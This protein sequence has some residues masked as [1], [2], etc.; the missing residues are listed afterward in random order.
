MTAGGGGGSSAP[1]V[2]PGAG[3]REDGLLGRLAESDLVEEIGLGEA[4]E[5]R[6]EVARVDAPPRVPQ[7]RRERR[8]V[9]RQWSRPRPV[10][11]CSSSIR[12][13]ASAFVSVSST[14]SPASWAR[15]VR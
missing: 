3:D 15:T 11:S 1:E 12:F 2:E 8:P 4:V 14:G 7:A 6:D 9:M 13:E 5:A 10:R